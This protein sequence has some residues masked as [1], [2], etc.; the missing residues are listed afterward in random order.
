M[1]GKLAVLA[2]LGAGYV[3]GARAGRRRYDQIAGNA[4]KLWQ[5]PRVAEKRHQAA[6]AA[7]E[8]AGAAK[9]AVT[10]K[11]QQKVQEHREDGTDSPAG[12]AGSAATD[13]VPASDLPDAPSWKV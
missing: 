10:E 2:G 13:S 8:H 11:V 4:R 1:K 7:K 3:L 5:D 9:D 6:S 12:T